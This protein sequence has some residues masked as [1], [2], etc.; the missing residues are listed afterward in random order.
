M[1]LDSQHLDAWLAQ[2]TCNNEQG[3][4]LLTDIIELA[5]KSNHRVLARQAENPLEVTGINTMTQLS[6]LERAMQIDNAHQLME[7]GVQLL[8]PSRFDLRGRVKTGRNV[9]IDINVILEGEVE[10]GDNVVLGPNVVIRDSVIKTGTEVRANSLIEESTLGA[11]CIIGP[12]ARLR[13]GTELADEVRIGNFVEIKKSKVGKGSKANHLAYLGDSTL[14][15][16]VNVGAGAITCNYDGVSKH[17]THIADGAFIG[18]NV[19]LVA[20]VSI[21]AGATIGAGSTITRDVEGQ[22]LA[23]ARGKQRVISNWRQ[24]ARSPK[25][26]AKQKE[27]KA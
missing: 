8:D 20:P 14:G 27:A 6:N 23:V 13:P 21:G 15:E 17:E 2:L 19:A 5:S 9:R 26:P 18:S 25:T 11:N 7:A 1:V 4:Y 12:Y 22:S 16:E 10:L 3:E 24:A